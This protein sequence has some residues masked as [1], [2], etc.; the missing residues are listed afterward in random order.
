MYI[1]IIGGH[2]SFFG[3][4]TIQGWRRHGSYCYFTGEQTKTFDEA[5]DGCKSLES[6]LVDVTNG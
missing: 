1:L 6:Y 2:C 3:L 5:K 4:T